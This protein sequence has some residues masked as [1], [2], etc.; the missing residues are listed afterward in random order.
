MIMVLLGYVNI[1]GSLLRGIILRIF[2]NMTENFVDG[3][4]V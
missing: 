3:P 4:T 1:E 2:S